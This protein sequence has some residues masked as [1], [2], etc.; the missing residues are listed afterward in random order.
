MGVARIQEGRTE[1][2]ATGAAP[3]T[4]TEPAHVLFPGAP[5]RDP[6]VSAR[7]SFWPI[8]E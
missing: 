3:E 5:L 6:M 4:S 2:P 1:K 7:P 8:A